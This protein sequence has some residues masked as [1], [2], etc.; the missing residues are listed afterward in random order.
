MKTQKIYASYRGDD[1]IGIGTIEEIAE[2]MN[3]SVNTAYFYTSPAHRK[4]RN[5][6]GI[7]V[8]RVEEDDE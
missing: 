1:L 5:E 4:R 8:F 2:L 3:V 6:D 7:I